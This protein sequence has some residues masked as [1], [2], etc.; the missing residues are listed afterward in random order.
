[1]TILITAA[2]GTI[3]AP[4]TRALAQSGHPVRAFVR[5]PGRARVLLG[6]DVPLAVGDFADPASLHRALDGVDRVFLAC[7]NVPDQVGHECAVV[8][9]CVRTGVSRVV[10]LS[11]PR[12]GLT[13]PILLERRHAQIEQHLQASRLPSTG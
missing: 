1:M 8:D 6:P 7:G 11:A 10:K 4:L 3:G 9:A 12:V 13:S 2:T 5:D